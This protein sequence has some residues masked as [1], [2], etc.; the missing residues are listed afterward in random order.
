MR[1]KRIANGKGSGASAPGRFAA[2]RV[3]GSKGKGPALPLAS[4][5]MTD[6]RSAVRQ[7]ACLPVLETVTSSA[8]PQQ[9][10]E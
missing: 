9:V 3:W 7:N 1:A 6:E 4:G 8:Q 5:M 2:P 10:S